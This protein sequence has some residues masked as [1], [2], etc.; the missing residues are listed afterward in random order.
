MAETVV[1][2]DCG[3]CDGPEEFHLCRKARRLD[4]RM[5]DA[6]LDLQGCYSLASDLVKYPITWTDPTYFERQHSIEEDAQKLFGTASE[7]QSIARKATV[8]DHREY[9]ARR[10]IAEHLRKQSADG[11][12]RE[13]V[14]EDPP[15][16]EF[17]EADLY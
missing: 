17:D 6:A 2:Y 1:V 5:M 8:A 15:E 16:D 11:D 10:A 9:R 3:C 13:E 14:I 12:Y 4:D 7:L